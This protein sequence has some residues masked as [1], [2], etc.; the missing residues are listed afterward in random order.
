MEMPPVMG[1]E[2]FAYYS[3]EIPAFFYFLGITDL[4]NQATSFPAHSPY[5]CPDEGSIPV[6]VESMVNL[7]LSYLESDRTFSLR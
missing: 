5:F 4:K 1:S 3:Q 6:G 7:V 2:D